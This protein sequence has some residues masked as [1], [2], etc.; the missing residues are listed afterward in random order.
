MIKD[1]CDGCGDNVYFHELQKVYLCPACEA[2]REDA[3]QLAS[4]LLQENN[5]LRAENAELRAALCEL[6]TEMTLEINK[7][8]YLT[9]PIQVPPARRASDKEG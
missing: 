6:V 9:T 4:K 1:K 8:R 2:V 7:A 5:A 3:P